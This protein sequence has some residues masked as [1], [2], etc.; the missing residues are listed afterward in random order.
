MEADRTRTED[1]LRAELQSKAE[2]LAAEQAARNRTEAALAEAVRPRTGDVERLETHLVDLAAAATDEVD[3]HRNAAQRRAAELQR[4]RSDHEA[5]AS[6]AQR[7]IA[8]LERELAAAR[9]ALEDAN[10]D[11]AAAAQTIETLERELA[12]VSSGATA[13]ARAHERALGEARDEAPR[14]RGPRSARMRSSRA[15]PTRCRR[16]RATGTRPRPRSG[17]AARPRAPRRAPGSRR[18]TGTRLYFLQREL[19]ATKRAAAE[20]K[21]G[22]AALRTEASSRRRLRAR[23]RTRGPGRAR[24]RLNKRSG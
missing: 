5:Q 9:T 2:A 10:T 6:N 13:A 15:R 4:A 14:R 18:R 16:P 7:R 24:P 23:R 3:A 1:D 11:D 8:A 12:H 21:G 19:E 20:R 22:A 17:A